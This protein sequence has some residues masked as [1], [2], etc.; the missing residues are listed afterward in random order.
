ENGFIKYKD[1][2]GDGVATASD[3]RVIIGNPY[4]D[5]IYGFNT[6]FEY[7]NFSLPAFFEG[8]SGDDIFWATAGAHLNSFQRGSNQLADLYANYWTEE[9]PDPN[10]KYPKVSSASAINVS[11]RYIEDGSYLRLRVL[12]LAYNI[13]TTKLGLQGFSRAQVY[14]TA[15]NLFTI[16]NYPG[17]DPEVNTRGNDAGDVGT[18]LL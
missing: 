3:D 9:N 7:K 16:T 1:F 4:P 10:A 14:L 11:D 5:F 18:R 12:R 17:L 2:N 6:N 15:N 13:P 8:V